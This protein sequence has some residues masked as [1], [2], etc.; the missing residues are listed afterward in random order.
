MNE[1]WRKYL[2][3]VLAAGFLAAVA[4]QW[5]MRR[6]VP[7][8][9]GVPWPSGQKIRGWEA[10]FMGVACLGGAGYLFARFYLESSVRGT[11]ALEV[12]MLLQ[13]GALMVF[14]VGVGVAL[15]FGFRP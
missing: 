4:V 6:E 3:G 10:V 8:E 1:R 13:V 14:I 2:I 12:T 15:W 9:D 5:V 11:R 7:L